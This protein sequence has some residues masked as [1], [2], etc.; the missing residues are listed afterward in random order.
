MFTPSVLVTAE[1]PSQL[2]SQADNSSHGSDPSA[3]LQLLIHLQK[4]L[5][6]Q[7]SISFLLRSVTDSTNLSQTQ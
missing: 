7:H 3:L 4:E 5:L 2:S 1:L 6:S